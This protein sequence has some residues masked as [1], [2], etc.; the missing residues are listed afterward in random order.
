MTP[1]FI[2]IG[3][4]NIDVN[5]TPSKTTVLPGGAGY[6]AALGGSL[7]TSS[8]GLVTRIG[9]D[10]DDTFL[11][12]RLHGEGIHKI[13]NKKT[14]RSIQTYHSDTDLTQRDI[15]LDWGVAPDLCPEDIPVSWFG[16]AHFVHIG[17]MPPDQQYAFI[18]FVRK[19]MPNAILSIDSD[20][21]LFSN[22]EM[23]DLIKRNFNVCDI[24]FM[25]RT[26]YG[27]LK[28][29][30]QNHPFVVVKQDKD[31]AFILHKG[32]VSCLI[33]AKAVTPK[34]VTGA[35]D[36]LAGV[37]LGCL[38]MGFSEEESLQKA[39]DIATN[40]ITADGIDHLFE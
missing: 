18:P 1:S 39:V 32:T 7:A 5:V 6:F 17:T 26:E 8:V 38:S 30:A 15:S 10:F 3:Y 14:A 31:G 9:E 19:N 33:K 21:Y 22:T 28:T 11:R 35:G 25:N 36:I 27:I 24:V 20:S 29:L 2:V 4:T 16:S 40:S 34:D 23:L 13:L 12:S 37:F